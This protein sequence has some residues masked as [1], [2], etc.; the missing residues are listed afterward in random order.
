MPALTPDRLAEL[1]R[2]CREA[3]PGPWFLVGYP[4]LPPNTN[5]YVIAGCED[6][7]GGT[8]VCDFDFVEDREQDDNSDADAAFIAA[9]RS[10]IPD[11]IAHV[12]ELEAE[13]ERLRKQERPL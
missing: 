6:P 12:R 10:A 3:T 11:L 13:N 7:H 4:W 2:L 8:L 1:D 5:T 9:A